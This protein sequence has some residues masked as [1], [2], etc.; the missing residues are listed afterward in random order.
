MKIFPQT[1]RLKSTMIESDSLLKSCRLVSNKNLCIEP[2]DA[3][4]NIDLEPFLVDYYTRQQYSLNINSNTPNYKQLTEIFDLLEIDMSKLD[5]L[6]FDVKD[7][8]AKP[9]ESGRI[10]FMLYWFEIS[11]REGN[12][13]YSPVPNGILSDSKTFWNQLVGFSVSDKQQGIDMSKHDLV[14]FDY[15]FKNQMFFVRDLNVGKRN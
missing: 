15:L 13:S 9:I 11:D 2:F 12:K 4:Q 3:V 8:E 6:D 7:F 1:I 10:D 14:K 5:R